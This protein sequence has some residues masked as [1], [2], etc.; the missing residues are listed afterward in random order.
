M[1]PKCA[2]FYPADSKTKY[3]IFSI[4]GQL[5]EEPSSGKELSELPSQ[6]QGILRSEGHIP[7]PLHVSVRPP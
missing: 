6:N 4:S 7:G 2:L 5:L 1:L 3:V